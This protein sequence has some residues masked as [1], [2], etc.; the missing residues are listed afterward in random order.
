MPSWTSWPESVDVV[1]V[2][3]QPTALTA[4]GVCP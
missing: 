4:Q 3:T 1:H 2:L